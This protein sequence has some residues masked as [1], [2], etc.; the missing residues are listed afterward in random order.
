[1]EAEKFDP[2]VVEKNS[3]RCGDFAAAKEME[4]VILAAA[5]RGDS[6]GGT[7]GI[8]IQNAP[9]GLGEPVFDKI[10]ALLGSALLSIGGVKGVEFGV[11]FAAAKLFGSEMNDEFI[12]RAKKIQKKTNRAGGILGGIS[13]GDEILIRLAVKPTASIA[14]KQKTVDSR[15]KVRRLEISGRHDPCLAP[16]IVPVAE[17]M[18]RIVLADL[19]L[20]SRSDRI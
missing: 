4:K 19:L 18:A 5:K 6:I 16:R 10:E 15:G 20:R 11:G 12:A 17:A 2:K 13:D 9:A 1:M 14:R 8:L 3:V 7:V